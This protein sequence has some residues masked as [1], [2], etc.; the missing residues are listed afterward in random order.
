MQFVYLTFF[1]LFIHFSPLL[2]SLF[3]AHVQNSSCQDT[4]FF[5]QK[6]H[7][8]VDLSYHTHTV[9]NRA[10]PHT[11]ILDKMMN[12]AA[13]FV[14]WRF[15][16]NMFAPWSQKYL[17]TAIV[18]TS[19]PSGTHVRVKRVFCC[20]SCCSTAFPCPIVAWKPDLVFKR[21]VLIAAA[22]HTRKVGDAPGKVHRKAYHALSYSHLWAI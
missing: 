10:H 20:I 9:K 21:C 8:Q 16:A 18:F 2:P 7:G 11:S 5:F 6:I 12:T 22:G 3:M 13:L 15:R 19:R 17:I 4:L 1:H 14:C